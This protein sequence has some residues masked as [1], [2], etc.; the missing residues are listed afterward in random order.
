MASFIFS[1]DY[2]TVTGVCYTFLSP[3]N[4]TVVNAWGFQCAYRMLVHMT[5]HRDGANAVRES[6]QKADWE[7]NL[8]AAF[9]SRTCVSKMLAYLM[10]G[11][12]GGELKELNTAGGGVEN[13][14]PSKTTL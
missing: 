3:N 14:F 4:G 11:G 7:K 12:E 1:E 5:A 13:V 6:G 2:S 8:L 10:G 9:Q